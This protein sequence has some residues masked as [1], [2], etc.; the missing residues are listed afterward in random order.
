MLGISATHGPHQVA[1]KS[2]TTTFPFRLAALTCAPLMA[3]V[4]SI[5]NG[6]PTASRIRR[7]LVNSRAIGLSG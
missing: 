4:N 1:Q 3:S 6:L 5:S 7:S 2:T